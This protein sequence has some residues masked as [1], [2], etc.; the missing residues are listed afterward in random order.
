MGTRT[1]S[2]AAAR[3]AQTKRLVMQ[4]QPVQIDLELEKQYRKDR[5]A[6]QQAR[7]SQ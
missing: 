7:P 2:N 3:S 4:M 5:Q 1:L 6:Q